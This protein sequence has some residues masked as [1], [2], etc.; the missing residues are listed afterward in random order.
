MKHRAIGVVVALG[1]LVGLQAPAWS[2]DS[3]SLKEML[4]EKG[5][6]TNAEAEKVQE[7]VIASW[8]NRIN[9]YG[10]LRIRDEQ[11]FPANNPVPPTLA[12]P[13]VLNGGVDENRVRFRLRFGADLKIHDFT[14][15][16]RLVSGTGQQV[17]T[18]Q[19]ETAL[20]TGKGIYIDKAY[21]SWQGSYTPWLKVTAGKM[22]NPYFVLY[23][24]DVVWDDDVNPE[25]FAENIQYSPDDHTN[26]FLNLGQFVLNEVGTNNHDPWMIGE[27]GGVAMSPTKDMKATLAMAFYES[28]NASGRD[29]TALGGTVQ[30]GNSRCTYGANA[31]VLCN[32]FR[33]LDTTAQLNL[34]AGPIP[35]S[36]MGDYVRNLANTTTTGVNTA[37]ATGNEGYQVG[38]IVGK[39]AD[40]RTWEFAY[41]Y[42]VLQTDATLADLADSDFGNG[43]TARRGHIMWAAYNPMKFLQVKVKYFITKSIPF[44]GGLATQSNA[45]DI[46][47]L[48]A[49]LSMKF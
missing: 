42:K 35:V 4:V 1:L 24:G 46:D 29:A 10:D 28:I 30:Q 2:E 3:V 17:S 39:A 21:L 41:F 22:A 15:G 16:F 12:P 13:G 40:A 5:V 31:G 44:D 47:R 34:K 7:N 8:V 9:F 45:G 20:F 38:A 23:S 19:T 27:Q 6:L 25:G 26:L 37:P 43:G 32:N 11:F 48:Q 36:I 49:D 33:V 18:N 14:V